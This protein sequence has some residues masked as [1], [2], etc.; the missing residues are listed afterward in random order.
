MLPASL[1]FVLGSFLTS[2]NL[3][4]AGSEGPD[5]VQTVRPVLSVWKR[6]RDIL[7]DALPLVLLQTSGLL[8]AV[9]GARL[10]LGL[11]ATTPFCSDAGALWLPIMVGFVAGCAYSLF[12][13]WL[14]RQSSRLE[15][16]LVTSMLSGGTPPPRLM[17]LVSDALRVIAFES[18][19]Y[20]RALRR[21]QIA[22]QNVIGLICNTAQSAIL[23]LKLVKIAPDTAERAVE[24]VRIQAARIVLRNLVGEVFQEHRARID[25][26]CRRHKGMS[27]E[28]RLLDTAP[29]EHVAVQ[30]QL[31]ARTLGA[32]GFAVALRE[33]LIE[34]IPQEQEHDVARI[35]LPSVPTGTSVGRVVGDIC[36]VAFLVWTGISILLY[37]PRDAASILPSVFIDATWMVLAPMLSLLFLFVSLLAFSLRS[38]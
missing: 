28:L 22:G 12:C 16:R 21:V 19:A 9:F 6:S 14:R 36:V 13:V 15:F 8:A 17:F 38:K 3:D 30:T 4:T 18:V 10:L 2:L 20:Q 32:A 31:L 5:G 33:T 27:D 24:I 35:R 26:Y 1:A 23:R 11:E 25:E 34:K 7:A 29:A 37:G